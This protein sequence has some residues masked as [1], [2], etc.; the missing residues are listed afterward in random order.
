MQILRK[1]L[2]KAGS[3]AF[4]NP[5]SGVRFLLFHEIKDSQ[6]GLFE[7]L[8]RFIHEKYG[9][10]SPE[11][12][13]RSSQ[14][15]GIRYILSFDDGFASQLEATRAILDPLDIKALF[16][17]CPGFIGLQGK[18][19]E[20]FTII[21]MRRSE[22]LRMTPELQ[23][24]SWDDLTALA[25]IGHVI[26]SHGMNHVTLSELKGQGDLEK[27][28]FGSGD[29]LAKRLGRA[30]EW[31]SYPFGNIDSI[32]FTALSIIARR[33]KYC[34]SGLRGINIGDTNRLCLSRENID[35][36]TF[37]DIKQL[38][39]IANGGLDFLYYSKRKKLNQMANMIAQDS[40]SLY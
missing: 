26:G 21:Q 33:Y 23:P 35:L 17:V 25:S 40:H 9:F 11:Y 2:L 3:F 32:D 20:Q 36:D 13:D 30:I 19:A 38:K 5:G 27:E 34:C 7:S 31:I 6:F 8:I 15:K 37:W 12:Y 22:V 14:M 1:W 24:L 10:I 4:A 29:V 39:Q 18:D 16:F 28:I